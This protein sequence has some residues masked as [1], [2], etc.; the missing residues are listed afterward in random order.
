MTYSGTEEAP[1]RKILP[2][3]SAGLAAASQMI[4]GPFGGDTALN[5]VPALRTPL[6]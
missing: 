2:I 1:P 6:G 3:L 5:L 4:L